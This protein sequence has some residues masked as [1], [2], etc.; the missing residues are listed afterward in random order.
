MTRNVPSSRL[1]HTAASSLLLAALAAACS[2]PATHHAAAGNPTGSGEPGQLVVQ[3][4]DI[5]LSITHAALHLDSAG[6][7]ALT[8]TLRNGGEAPEHLDMVAAPGGERGALA[9]RAGKGDGVLDS[10]GILVRPGATVTFGGGGPQIRFT[11]LRG[12]SGTLPLAFEF[13][14]AGLVHLDVVVQ[15]T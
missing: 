1:R 12:A 5:D 14:I 2:Q 15:H 10:A 8:M 11:G 9:G 4:G 13:G 6:S 3:T 7:G